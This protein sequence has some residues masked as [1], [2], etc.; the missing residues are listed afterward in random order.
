MN[1]YQKIQAVS[2][3]IKNIEKTLKVAA[4]TTSSYL[5]V[6]DQD[7][8][9][10]VNKAETKHGLVSF[11]IMQALERSEIVKV[12]KKDYESLVYV[13]IVKMTL[14]VVDI[15]D[16]TSF[17]DTEAYG[18]GWDASDKGFGKASTYARKY[19]LLNLYKIATGVDPDANK[20]E[21]QKAAIEPDEKKVL[22]Q[23]FCN[24]DNKYL[25]SVLSH[26]NVGNFDDMTMEQINMTFDTLK[27]KK[28]L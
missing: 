1:I 23:N 16:P 7:V 22:V 14:R 12:Q 25:Q 2:N 20:S 8:I 18:R 26:F 5:A 11:P 17:I 27:Q 28:L 10:Q 3:E 19:C 6:S 9:L 21:E 13:D 15:D 4:T 24:K